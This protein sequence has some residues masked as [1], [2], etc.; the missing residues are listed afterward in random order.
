MPITGATDDVSRDGQRFLI[1]TDAKQSEVEPM[2]IV[3]N[4]TAKLKK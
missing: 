2:S 1:N 4:W 3:L